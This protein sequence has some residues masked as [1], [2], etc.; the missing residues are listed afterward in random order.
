MTRRVI[1][2]WTAKTLPEPQKKFAKSSRVEPLY[3]EK[4]MTYCALF[5]YISDVVHA[6][7]PEVLIETKN[8]KVCAEGF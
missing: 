1:C 5:L 6:H 2:V 4:F 7:K 3:Y 8:S